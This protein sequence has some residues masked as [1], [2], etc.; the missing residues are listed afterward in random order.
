MYIY[1]YTCIY[2]HI[3]YISL[4]KLLTIFIHQTGYLV[5]KNSKVNKF[6]KICNEN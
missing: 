6:S 1:I 5:I 4:Y 3:I 2:N